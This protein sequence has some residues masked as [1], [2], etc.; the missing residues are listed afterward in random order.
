MNILGMIVYGLL[1][2][3]A[4]SWAWGVR[5]HPNYTF[6]T[7]LSSLLLVIFAILIPALKMN[8]LHALWMIPTGISFGVLL[9]MAIF[10]CMTVPGFPQ[11][12]QA[13]RRIGFAYMSL[14]RLGVKRNEVPDEPTEAKMP[15]LDGIDYEGL[16]PEPRFE[17]LRATKHL[18][19]V[20]KPNEDVLAA[21]TGPFSLRTM[22]SRPL[23]RGLAG[24]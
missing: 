19:S 11:L 5:V 15:R 18:F 21:A 9:T 16:D 10:P 22:D 6:G 3:I 13:L 24:C 4:V 12:L 8:R 14:L 2:V 7:G 17:A 1:V 20:I 23:Q